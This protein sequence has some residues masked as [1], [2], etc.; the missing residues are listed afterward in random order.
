MGPSLAL[1]LTLGTGLLAGSYPA[2]YLS[3]FQSVVVL[4]GKLPADQGR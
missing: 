4:K 1:A 3:G 2:F